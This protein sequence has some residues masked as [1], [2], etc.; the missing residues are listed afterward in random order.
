MHTEIP[1]DVYVRAYPVAF[2]EELR[3]K[4][5]E[6]FELNFDEGYHDER[7]KPEFS[8]PDDVI[9]FLSNL[10]NDELGDY[11]HYRI[12]YW[13]GGHD[14]GEA[15]LQAVYY[16]EKLRHN[17]IIDGDVSFRYDSVDELITSL[18]WLEAE[19]HKVA[20]MLGDTFNYSY[21]GTSKGQLVDLTT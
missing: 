10:D 14:C 13:V 4:I 7:F 18:V 6:S 15:C 3:K 9:E 8:N 19:A 2:R 12:D 11:L 17:V 5:I 16:S 20:D 1:L 21:A